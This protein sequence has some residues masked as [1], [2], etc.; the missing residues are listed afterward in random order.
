M[1]YFNKKI[2][3]ELLDKLCEIGSVE[4]ID[5]KSRK[6]KLLEMDKTLRF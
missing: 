3:M 2:S 6:N 4:D 1:Y 5:K